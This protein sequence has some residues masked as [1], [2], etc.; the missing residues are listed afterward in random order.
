MAPSKNSS[1]SILDSYNSQ[2]NPQNVL[3]RMVDE[4]DVGNFLAQNIPQQVATATEAVYK[5][6]DGDASKP[7]KFGD[8]G[9]GFLRVQI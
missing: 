6:L 3:Q 9:L 4:D 5:D 7:S 8:K 1:K 2:S